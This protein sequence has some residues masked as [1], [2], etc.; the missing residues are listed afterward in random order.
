MA[1]CVAK[2]RNSAIG[3]VSCLPTGNPYVVALLAVAVAALVRF[4]LDP[5]VHS[6]GPFL[7]FAVGVLVAALF[8]GFKAG[9]A[10][11]ILSVPICDYFFIDPRYTW[12]EYDARADSFML[13][14]F[15]LLGILAS[16]V[17]E[18]LNRAQQNLRR[19]AAALELS[20]HKLRTL[21]ATV[22]EILF[23]AMPD[24]ATDYIGKRFCDYSGVEVDALLG[25][26]WHQMLHSDDKDAASAAWSQ[27]F[28]TGCDYEA[29]FRLRR[30]DGV[31]RWFKCHATPVRDS[32]HEVT[33]WFGV[34]TDIDDHKNL[35]DA[36]TERTEKLLQ[37]NE[38][39]DR[40]AH[41]ASHDLQEPL[42]T[43][44][45]FS[46]ML[47]EKNRDKLDKDSEQFARYILDGVDRM[48]NLIRDLLEYASASHAETERE[49]YTDLNAV[50]K[51]AMVH[52][53]SAITGSGAIVSA[54]KLPAI[55]TNESCILRIFQN[56][57]ANAIKYRSSGTPV[58]HISAREQENE[59]VVSVRDNG[60]GFDMKYAEHIFGPFKR[61]HLNS[62]IKG[63]GIGLAIVRRAVKQCGGRVWAES[64]PG[65]GSTFSFTLPKSAPAHAKAVS[66]NS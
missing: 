11:T 26:G 27:A 43:I 22:P 14:L 15:A 51:S 61:L 3:I 31:Y 65:K 45:V 30:S 54:G 64:E 63:T 34:C 12:F 60:I 20:E 37:L 23:T 9:I 5:L 28:Q 25:F 8:G 2:F 44:G 41:M 59:W 10:A 13:A 58:I 62:Q 16:V 39:L 48:D 66:A 24:G 1:E 18:R 21:A 32:R 17:V 38:D 33:K 57:I 50:L 52:L 6:K 53:D 36:L 47:L 29:T 7:F 46:Q 35:E 42:R 4:A 56:L 19:S 40:F 55:V 49:N